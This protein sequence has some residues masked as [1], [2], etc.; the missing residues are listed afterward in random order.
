MAQAGSAFP[1]AASVSSPQTGRS[2]QAVKA[3]LSQGGSVS[4][5]PGRNTGNAGIQ[6]QA[7]STSYQAASSAQAGNTSSQVGSTSPQPGR[8]AGNAGG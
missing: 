5:Q 8:N 2:S 6:S 4:L 1:Q 7:G 3:N